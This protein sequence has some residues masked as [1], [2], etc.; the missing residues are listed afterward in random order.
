MKW[1]IEN[2]QLDDNLYL[3][4]TFLTLGI[5][6]FQLRVDWLITTKCC[7][8]ESTWSALLLADV[9]S[10]YGNKSPSKITH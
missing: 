1:T 6:S 7:P 2:M 10:N 8:T 3:K 5:I 4:M 9:I